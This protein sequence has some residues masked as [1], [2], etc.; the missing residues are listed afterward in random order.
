[1][2]L[3]LN[4]LIMFLLLWSLLKWSLIVLTVWLGAAYVV[5]KTRKRRRD[6]ICVVLGSGGH[7]GEMLYMMLKYDFS[8]WKKVYCVIGD[9]DTLSMNKM[10]LF[11]QKN[12]VCAI[13]T[14]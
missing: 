12:N 1:M 2:Y 5:N 11:I 14:L 8:K 4:F 7:T 6:A 3:D 10:K 13:L 9:N